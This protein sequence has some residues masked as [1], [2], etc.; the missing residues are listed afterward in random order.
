ME[1]DLGK[2]MRETNSKEW[3][4]VKVDRSPRFHAIWAGL[5]LSP[6][7]SSSAVQPKENITGLGE[8]ILGLMQPK[9]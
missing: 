5:L 2:A 3:I 4:G 8:Q 1:L 7:V 9:S 6:F